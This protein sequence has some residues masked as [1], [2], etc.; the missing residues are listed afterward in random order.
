MRRCHLLLGRMSNC[1]DCFTFQAVK[2]TIGIAVVG[3][4]IAEITITSNAI[5]EKHAASAEREVYM[6]SFNIY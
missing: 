3:Q 1:I 6:Y 4:C 5:V 2:T